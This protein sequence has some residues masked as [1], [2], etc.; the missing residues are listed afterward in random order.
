M[1]P[2]TTAQLTTPNQVIYHLLDLLYSNKKGTIVEFHCV[3]VSVLSEME[4]M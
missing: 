4:G 1:T 3:S 2:P